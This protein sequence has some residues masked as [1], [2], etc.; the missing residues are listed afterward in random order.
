LLLDLDAGETHALPEGGAGWSFDR[1]GR[2]L[3][4]VAAPPDSSCDIHILDLDARDH[5]T[6][7]IPGACPAAD[8]LWVD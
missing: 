3:M 8:P 7:V 4:F 1:L 2:Y 6:H 5:T